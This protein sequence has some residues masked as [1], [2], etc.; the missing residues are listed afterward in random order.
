MEFVIEDNILKKCSGEDTELV[1]PEGVIEIW[2]GAFKGCANLISISLPDSIKKVSKTAFDMEM[3][4]ENKRVVSNKKLI[5]NLSPKLY[6]R[7]IKKT[8]QVGGQC[9]YRF[10]GQPDFITIKG[11]LYYYQ[12]AEA[13]ITIPKDVTS[14]YDSAFYEHPDLDEI[15]IPSN[16]KEIGRWAF[17]WC[18]KLRKVVFEDNSIRKIEEQSFMNCSNLKEVRLP[19]GI[20]IIGKNA[21]E[22]TENLKIINFPDSIGSF[23]FG[24][25]C[26]SGLSEI[27]F[28][29]NVKYISEYSFKNMKNLSNKTVIIPKSCNVDKNAF[30]EDVIIVN[31]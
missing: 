26:S 22:G 9:I 5:C 28:S 11:V 4:D 24:A 1:V 15:T 12:G 29:K 7:L 21:F 31:E 18:K 20:E 10:P 2:G 23:M 3:F 30:D 27:S 8:Q 13:R 17:Y 25:F 14:I 16:V 6:T 19:E